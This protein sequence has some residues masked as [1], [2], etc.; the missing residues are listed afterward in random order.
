M[1]QLVAYAIT[2]RVVMR[3]PYT[4]FNNVWELVPAARTTP[5]YG[6]TWWDVKH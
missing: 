2:T 4:Q 5:L 1:P 6:A 3:F